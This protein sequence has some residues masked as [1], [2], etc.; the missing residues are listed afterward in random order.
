GNWFF[1]VDRH[2]LALAASNIAALTGFASAICDALAEAGI[3]GSDG[4][5]IDHIELFAP[6]SR[7]ANS[8]SF[9]LCPGLAYDRSPCGTGTS[10]KQ[11]CL[12]ADGKLAEHELWR[13]ESI[14]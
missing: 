13:Q 9:V 6:S 7:G 10:A 2:H 14:I 8:R 5:P 1:L 11:A 4:A 12:A 3:T